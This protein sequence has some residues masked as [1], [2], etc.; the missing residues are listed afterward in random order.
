MSL[1]FT[2]IPLLNQSSPF[3]DALKRINKEPLLEVLKEV[4]CAN[5]PAVPDSGKKDWEYGSAHVSGRV[6]GWDSWSLENGMW[7]GG[8]D[9]NDISYVGFYRQAVAN[10]FTNKVEFFVAVVPLGFSGTIQPGQ[11]VEVKDSIPFDWKRED[12]E[13]MARESFAKLQELVV[14]YHNREESD[15]QTDIL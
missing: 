6:G 12:V 15:G 3:E 8:I 9:L 11:T 7:P 14:E 4:A 1:D 13:K 5:P 10:K 2:G